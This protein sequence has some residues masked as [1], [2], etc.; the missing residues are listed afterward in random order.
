MCP[1]RIAGRVG[2]TDYRACIAQSSRI[3]EIDPT[4]GHGG[5]KDTMLKMPPD[6]RQKD[7]CRRLELSGWSGTIKMTFLK[8]RQGER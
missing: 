2:Y 8:E 3:A 6:E 4:H 5:R 1:F 7:P